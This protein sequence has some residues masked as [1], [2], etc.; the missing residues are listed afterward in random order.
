MTAIKYRSEPID[1]A[2]SGNAETSQTGFA[3]LRYNV[4]TVLQD[5][6]PERLR[7]IASAL[8]LPVHLMLL[9]LDG[10]MNIA[11]SIRTAA[12][13]GCSDVWVVGQRRYD[14]RPEVGSKNY[15][16]VRKLRT[17]GPNPAIFFESAGIQPILIEQGGTPIEEMNFKRFHR[18]GKPVCFVMG[19]E[20]HGIPDEFALALAAAPRITIS[21]YGLVRSLN[22]S[23]AA[24]IVMYEYLKQW[25][26]ARKDV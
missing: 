23:I 16:N 3:K 12:V 5:K 24:S 1:S 15:I 13:L 20:S 4:H 25:R 2:Q 22:V 21:Q 26:M 9:N 8:A 19:S 14:A 17:L 10:N 7:E 6:P 18:C 11:M